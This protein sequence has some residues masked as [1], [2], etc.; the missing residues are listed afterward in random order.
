MKRGDFHL[1]ENTEIMLTE[2]LQ[3]AA[4]ACGIAHTFKLMAKNLATNEEVLVPVGATVIITSEATKVIQ[5][6]R[7]K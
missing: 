6:F 2:L 7:N 3:T 4:G 5:S 1:G